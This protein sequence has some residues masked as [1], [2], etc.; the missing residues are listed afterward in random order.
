MDPYFYRNTSAQGNCI[1]VLVQGRHRPAFPTAAAGAG[2][3]SGCVAVFC[4][5]E[6]ASAKREG[7]C[8]CLVPNWELFC[9]LILF[10][11]DSAVS[12][13]L[14]QGPIFLLHPGALFFFRPWRKKKRGP[15]RFLKNRLHRT[16]A[17]RMTPF[18]DSIVQTCFLK[19]SEYA[20]HFFFSWAQ[21]KKERAA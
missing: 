14:I 6:K 1:A 13:S 18:I 19:R 8:V 9:A 2:R 3:G 11:N 7:H 12:E 21:E 20:P 16:R 15:F 10:G 5:T 17:Q 4:S